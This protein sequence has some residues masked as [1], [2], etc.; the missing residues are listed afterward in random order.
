MF[1]FLRKGDLL[2]VDPVPMEKI[3][4]GDVLVFEMGEK[5]IAHRVIRVYYNDGRLK[6]ITRGDARIRVD[7]L[8]IKE[9]Y[10]GLV[11]ILERNKKTVPLTSF[12]KK[13]ST[14][15][16]LIGGLPLSYL[17]NFLVRKK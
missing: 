2:T 16:H 4:R 5:W 14:Q 10:I 7:K 9:N 12:R 8:V 13:I 1:P 3:Q 11:S 17:L 6:I 15:I